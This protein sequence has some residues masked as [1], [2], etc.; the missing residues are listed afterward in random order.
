MKTRKLLA[1]YT[2]HMQCTGPNGYAARFLRKH[3]HRKRFVELA[4]V[5]RLM[6]A[7]FEP[8]RRKRKGD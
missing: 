4:Q 1:I 6:W 3:R 8:I 5:A 7:A 2:T